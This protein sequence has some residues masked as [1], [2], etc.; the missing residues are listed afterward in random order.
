M[1]KDTETQA[2]RNKARRRVVAAAAREIRRRERLLAQLARLDEIVITAALDTFESADGAA[3]WLVCPAFGLA[4]AIPVKV[5]GT[6]DGRTQ[7]VRL[8]G[9]IEHGVFF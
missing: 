6:K 1:N 7:V 2:N 8:L 5:A 9:A 3:E 4:G